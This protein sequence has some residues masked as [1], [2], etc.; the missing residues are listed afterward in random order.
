GQ[1][2]VTVREVARV[3][4]LLMAYKVPVLTSAVANPSPVARAE[5]LALEVLAELLSGGDSARLPRHLLREQEVAASANAG[6]NLAD[7]LESLFTL[8]AIPAEGRDLKALET[9]LRREIERIR[10]ET[11]PAEEMD[12]VKAR[13]IARKVFEQDSMMHQAMVIGVLESAGLDW[14]LKDRHLEAV[15][16]VTAEEVRQVA[17]R[18]LV[19]DGLTV[20]VLEPLPAPAAGKD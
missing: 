16:A 5:V 20:A 10:S 7:R 17:T 8:E 2:R 13:V 19:D 18:Y 4:H 12:R 1:R 6:Y 14:R 3:P 9:A 11:V 15:K